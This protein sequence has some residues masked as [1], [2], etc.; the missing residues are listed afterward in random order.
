VD[1]DAADRR[2]VRR[3]LQVIA[4][5]LVSFAGLATVAL[6]FPAATAALERTLL[7]AAGGFAFAWV[8]GIFLGN[9]VGHSEQEVVREGRQPLG[10]RSGVGAV[11]SVV[12]VLALALSRLAPALPRISLAGLWGDAPWIAGAF[13]L[14]WVGGFLMGH[15]APRFSRRAR[16]SRTPEGPS[17]TV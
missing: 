16:R 7:P 17:N 8:G 10:S 14:S 3:Q 15:A 12:G 1:V 6:G 13:L 4:G 5:L 11:S 2:R 9:R